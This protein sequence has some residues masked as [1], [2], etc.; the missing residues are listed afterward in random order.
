[1]H[2]LDNPG[3]A[4][5]FERFGKGT[6]AKKKTT[7]IQY[8]QICLYCKSYNVETQE[9]KRKHVD[10][11]KDP[12]RIGAKVSPR[13]KPDDANCK[14]YRISDDASFA[15][16]EGGIGYFEKNP[17]AE[18]RREKTLKKYESVLFGEKK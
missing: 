13:Q 10:E 18:F 11:K 7:V 6:M 3:G 16:S 8:D 2:A 5:F 9:C 14:Y 12:K 15:F 17:W 4:F 1:M